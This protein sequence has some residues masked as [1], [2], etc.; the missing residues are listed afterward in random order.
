[1]DI[2]RP[3]LESRLKTYFDPDVSHEE[4]RRLAP[5]VMERTARFDPE[6]TRD[7][8]RKRG[9]RPEGIVR[10]AYRPFDVRWL[11][12]EGETD[13]LDRNRAEYVPHINEEN[14]WLS[15]GQ[16]NRKEDF[17]QPQ[18]TRQLA[19]HHLVES[20]VGMFP[21]WLLLHQTNT[22]NLSA[23]A[24][25]IL[26]DLA[27]D[28]DSLF[29]HV[30]SVLHSPAYKSE[31]K[32]A[33][34]QDWPRIPLPKS[35]ETLISSAGLGFQIAAL[36]DTETPVPGVTIGKINDD[37]KVLAVFE[38]TDGKQAN[39]ASGDLDLIVGWGHAGKGGI[40]MPGKG[41]VRE[42]GGALDIYLNE[43][44]RW[45]NVPKAVWEY[46][47]GGYQVIKKWLSYREKGLLGRG[48]TPDEVR[49]VTEMARRIAALI[50]LLP[51]L[52][53]NYRKVIKSTYPWPRS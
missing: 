16:R 51:A 24:V 44:T 10:Y 47:I 35:K 34:R 31:N 5:G 49:Y 37:L 52:D 20:N 6:K 19:D 12:W 42:S 41:L 43:N 13:L 36:L 38:R 14:V 4:M 53:E 17:Y 26:K 9:F 29:F 32:S 18:F 22:P 50:A 39:P 46:T 25:R 23:A 48:L 27:V 28:A 21:L 11:Y 45:R 8:L 15:A 7:Y 30:L 33:L 2:D 3:R 40:T 1:V